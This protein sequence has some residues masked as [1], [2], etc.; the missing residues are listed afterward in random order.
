ML[1]NHTAMKSKE[2][3]ILPH[4]KGQLTFNDLSKYDFCSFSLV[5]FYKPASQKESWEPL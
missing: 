5:A 4:G 2:K 3:N 1:E